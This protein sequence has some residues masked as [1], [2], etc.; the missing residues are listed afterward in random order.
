MHTPYD[1][2]EFDR[3]LQSLCGDREEARP[4]LCNGFPFG[5]EIFLVGINPGTST[6]FWPHWSVENGCDKKAWLKSYLV[7]HGKYGPTRT[8]IERLF[9]AASPARILETNVFHLPSKREGALVKSDQSTIVFDFLLRELSPRVIFVHGQSAVE[10]LE[11]IVNIGLPRG[12]FTRAVYAG[13]D[14]SIF[15]G[16]HLS[17]QW[18]FSAVDALG[19]EL[20]DRCASL[21]HADG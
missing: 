18:S 10:H 8:R 9:E 14:L 1:A 7:D 20:R 17:Y 2:A 21:K 3:R 16:H 6:R 12:Q 4:F 11:R 15:P 19:R 5:C 13:R